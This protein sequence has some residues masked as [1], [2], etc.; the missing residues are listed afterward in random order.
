YTI[1][2]VIFFSFARRTP[3]SPLFPYTTLFRSVSGTPSRWRSLLIGSARAL[4][5]CRSIRQITLGGEISDQA[6]LDALGRV[7]PAARITHVYATTEAGV[8]LSVSDRR[9]GF[10]AAWLDADRNGVRLR[11][12]NGEL[13]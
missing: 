10:P 2:I 11:V 12:S 1:I 13:Y 7:L 5:E 3:D 6:I 8:L 9:A 4:A